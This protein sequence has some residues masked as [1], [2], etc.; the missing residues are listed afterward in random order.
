[1]RELKSIHIGHNA[2]YIRLVLWDCHKN[3]LNQYN[4]VSNVYLNSVN[5]AEIADLCLGMLLQVGLAAIRV[6]GQKSEGHGDR[7]VSV[8][9]GGHSGD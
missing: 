7:I 8:S 6:V 1:V 5:F 9:A 4:Q 2:E 3:M